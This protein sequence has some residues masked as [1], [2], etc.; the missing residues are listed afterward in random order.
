M[1]TCPQ[2][3]QEKALSDYQL[4]CGNYHG[5]C[6]AC[7]KVKR[8]QRSVEINKTSYAWRKANRD[9]TREYN[10]KYRAKNKHKQHAHIIVELAVKSGELKRKSCEV[11]NKLYKK[12]VLAEAHHCDY[13]KPLEV[14]WLC[15]PHHRAWHRVFIAEA[16]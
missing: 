6:K 10:R 9:K 4:H 2:C 15:S 1:K 5:A 12:E 13:S 11:C 14:Q 16:A 7:K 3:N 8:Q